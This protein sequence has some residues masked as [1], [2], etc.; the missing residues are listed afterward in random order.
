M[1][2]SATGDSYYATSKRWDIHHFDMSSVHPSNPATAP[3][4]YDS[5]YP[6]PQGFGP[7][8]PYPPP[9]GYG[10]PPAPGYG[11][12]PPGY[13]PPP[14]Q[15]YSG[16]PPQGYGVYGQQPYGYGQPGVYQQNPPQQVV[17]VREER[18]KSDDNTAETCCILALYF[19]C[20]CNFSVHEPNLQPLCNLFGGLGIIYSAQFLQFGEK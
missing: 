3:P 4:P 18:R 15:G 14:P 10:A 8:A 2:L 6:P 19:T 17:Y 11:P 13:G 5:A 9:Q 20:C 12:P 7:S 1:G 16:P